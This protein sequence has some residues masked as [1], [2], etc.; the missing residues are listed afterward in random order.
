[1][2]PC[3][4]WA[5]VFLDDCYVGQRLVGGCVHQ[6]SVTLTKQLIELTLEVE[7]VYFFVM[8]FLRQGLSNYLPGLG[9]NLDPDPPYPCLLSS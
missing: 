6:F 5:V 7:K 3:T 8:G 1:M 9:L 2:A 4:T